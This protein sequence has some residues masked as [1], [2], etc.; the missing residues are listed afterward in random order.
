MTK[1]TLTDEEKAE[2][3]E[4]WAEGR[5]TTDEMAAKRD[6]ILRERQTGLT[7]ADLAEMAKPLPPGPND[8]NLEDLDDDGKRIR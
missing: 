4:A 6:A 1:P 8:Y 3:I 5:I 2:L 7:D